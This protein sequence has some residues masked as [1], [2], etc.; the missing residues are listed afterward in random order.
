M[1]PL[2]GNPLDFMPF[3]ISILFQLFIPSIYY[4]GMIVSY[5]ALH[6]I[7]RGFAIAA[8]MQN[9]ALPPYFLLRHRFINRRC[10]VRCLP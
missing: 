6:Y 3:S 7:L 1:S 5:N 2:Q 4:H 8:A 9:Q 10:F